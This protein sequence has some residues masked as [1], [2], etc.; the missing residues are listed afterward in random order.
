MTQES[1][2]SISLSHLGVKAHMLLQS[3]HQLNQTAVTD[4]PLVCLL[5]VFSEKE[6]TYS[7]CNR[8]DSVPP[9]GLPFH[10]LVQVR[11]GTKD[12]SYP[13]CDTIRRAF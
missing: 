10:Y 12:L 11:L 6:S 9:Q 3:Q 7:Q 1:V 8:R 2:F 4:M 5:A 13:Q